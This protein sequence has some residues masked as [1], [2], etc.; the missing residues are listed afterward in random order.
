MFATNNKHKFKEIQ[1]VTGDS[2]HL[3]SLSDLGFQEEIP[4]D[5]Q[6]LEE[7]AAQK[8]RHVF[9]RFGLSC[10]ADDTGL[11]IEA[12]DGKPGVFSARYAGEKCNFD[13][14][15]NKV[16][17]KMQGVENRKARFRTVIALVEKGHVRLFEGEIQGVITRERKGKAGF[18]Y[19]P[20]FQPAGH[21]QTFAEMQPSEKNRISHRTLAIKE[22][23]HYLLE[24]AGNP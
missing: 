18:G 6:S 12:L 24:V 21:D 19:D 23:V 4:E 2:I 1:E 3:V 7:N 10:F 17:A 20:I 14:N 15:I 5:F 11:E 13:D 16:L 9:E 8:A 22:L